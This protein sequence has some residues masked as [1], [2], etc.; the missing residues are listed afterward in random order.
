MDTEIR[1]R[2]GHYKPKN[3]TLYL[4]KS[5]E[6]QASCVN[7]GNVPLFVSC[8]SLSLCFYSFQLCALPCRA[9]SGAGVWR[10]ARKARLLDS[11]STHAH[12]ISRLG[13][14]CQRSALTLA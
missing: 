3:V 8:A 1:A 7:I 5:T 11:I 10:L 4:G 6:K 9:E 13:S 2:A 14:A 12:T